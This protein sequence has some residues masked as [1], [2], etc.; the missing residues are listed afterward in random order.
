MV[1]DGL[2]GVVA[3]EDSQHAQVSQQETR[4]GTRLERCHVWNFGDAIA[5]LLTL[6]QFVSIGLR[7]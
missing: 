4:G 3:D 2:R 7:L 1:S 5:P 6:L